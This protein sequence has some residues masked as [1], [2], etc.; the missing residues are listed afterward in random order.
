MTTQHV[1]TPEGEQDNGQETRQKRPIDRSSGFIWLFLAVI[2]GAGAYIIG[3]RPPATTTVWTPVRDL[4][5]YHLITAAD[6]ITKTV[7]V[8]AAPEK[9]VSASVAPDLR[10][11]QQP[12][13]AGQAIQESQIVPVS[14]QTLISDTVPVS[15]PATPAMAF[16]GRLAPGAIVTVWTVTDTGQAQPLLDEALVLDVQKVEM[17]SESD[18]NAFPYVVVLAVPRPKQAELLTTIA[19]G[20]LMLTLAP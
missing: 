15:L 1:A 8:S 11:A 2:I 5:V 13:T 10:Y 14:S 6:V 12:L 16:N 20:S 7:P 9:P 4:P 3:Q 17:Q 19:T 18:E